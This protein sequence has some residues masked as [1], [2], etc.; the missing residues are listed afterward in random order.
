MSDFH[1]L[2]IIINKLYDIERTQEKMATT[3]AQI[4]Q[5]DADL[6][7]AV[8]QNTT[9]EGNLITALEDA[10]AKALNNP[11]PVATA[12]ALTDMQA[13]VAALKANNTAM[14]NVLAAP[15]TP[16]AGGT[17]DPNTPAS[18]TTDPNAPAA[19]TTGS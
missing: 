9:D 12:A 13:K 2:R 6:A 18:G 3:L 7:A 14:E 17:T 19:G 15:A 8:Q 5:I 4:Q 1:L 16:P 11:D 10:L